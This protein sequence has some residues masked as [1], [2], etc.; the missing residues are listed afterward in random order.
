MAEQAVPA[1]PYA[2]ATDKLRE[3]TKWLFTGIVATAGAVFAGSSLTEL[4]T[5]DPGWRLTLA[6]AGLLLGF[7]GLAWLARAAVAV[8]TVH[9]GTPRMIAEKD[10]FAGVRTDLDAMF[11]GS[12]MYPATDFASQVSLVGAEFD[13]SAEQRDDVWLERGAALIGEATNTASF[14]IVRRQ[15]LRLV[16][17]MWWQTMLMIAGFGLFAWA[18][19]PPE[20]PPSPKPGIE[21]QITY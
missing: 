12:W 19:N 14:L 2:S 8:L 7:A 1:S 4:G 5:L 11:A 20:K 3:T 10:E 17:H 15:F 9:L 16:R 13:K 21:L 18:A 6:G